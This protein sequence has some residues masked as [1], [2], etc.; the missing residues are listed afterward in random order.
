MTTRLFQ[1]A[2]LTG[3][4]RASAAASTPGSARSRAVMSSN[5]S[6]RAVSRHGRAAIIEVHDQNAVLPESG[7]EGHQVPQ[8]A[9]E[10]QRADDEHE[11]QRD[12]R[13]DQAAP[14]A[15]ALA[16]V[17]RPAAAGFHRCAG[18]R[19]R[20]RE[21]PGAG[22]RS[23]RSPAA[24]APVNA[25][26]RQSR[27]ERRRTCGSISV[28]SSATRNAAQPLGERR[29]ADGAEQRRA[30]GFRRAAG[31][32]R[33]RATRRARAGRR[34]RV[35]ARSR[36]PASGSRGSRTRSAGR[37]RSSPAAARAAFRSRAA[38]IDTPVPAGNAPSLNV[39]VVLRVV[40]PVVCGSVVLKMRRRNRRELRGRALDR[41]ARLQAA[42]R[43]R[44]TRRRAC[45]A[46]CATRD[47]RLGA[48]RH[49]DVERRGRLRRRRTAAASRRRS[50]RR[51]RRA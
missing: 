37:G 41:P 48:E 25:K 21:S 45:R 51:G 39:Q 40:G 43:S 30:A 50:R 44:E 49:R 46:R 14:Q 6:R 19:R 13:D 18:L 9:D 1:P 32:R 3:T 42:D 33:G 5:A 36:A 23:G 34:F 38:A 2:P 47:E 26:T 8:A 11:R 22:R 15:E 28:V 16:R 17:G 10:Q 24:S 35:R 20:W 4:M 31:G 7:V 12:L 27:G 29:A